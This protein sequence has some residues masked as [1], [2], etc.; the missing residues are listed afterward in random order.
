MQL[1]FVPYTW[2]QISIMNNF[3]AI[4][5]SVTVFHSFLLTSMLS[6]PDEIFTDAV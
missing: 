3:A 6:F 5:F 2:V 4:R 1:G